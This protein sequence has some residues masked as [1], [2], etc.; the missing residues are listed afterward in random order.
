VGSSHNRLTSAEDNEEAL[1]S[2]YPPV[3]LLD[4]KRIKQTEEKRKR[5]PYIPGL[6]AEALRLGRVRV[7]ELFFYLLNRINLPP[8]SPHFG[9]Y[10]G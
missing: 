3:G 10:I 1:L 6:N 2:G 8:V 5:Q 4:A 9:F 7:C